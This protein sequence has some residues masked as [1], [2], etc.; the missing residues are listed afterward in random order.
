VHPIEHLRHVARSRGADPAVLVREA[1]TALRSMQFDPAGLVVACRRIVERHP[2]CG[3]LWWLCAHLLASNDPAATAR[4][5]VADIERDPTVD[6]LV[7][8]V[9][10]A[11]VVVVAGWPELAADALF[12]RGDVSVRVVE[13]GRDGSALATRLERSEVVADAVPAEAMFAAATT[14]DVVLVEASAVGP[15]AAV[16]AL[17]GATLAAAAY[18]AGTPVWLVAGRGRRLPEAMLEAMLER[19]AGRGPSWALTEECL[20]LELVTH[21]AGPDGIVLRES[22]TSECPLTPEL[23]RASPM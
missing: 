3:P 7:D 14:A 2:T 5:R 4:A 10:D 12:R 17:G 18:C 23:L 19:L 22:L 11:A 15:N 21:V 1:A 16:V 20:P 13:A 6:R 9:A 8:A